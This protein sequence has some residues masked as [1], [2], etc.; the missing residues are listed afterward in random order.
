MSKRR[1]NIFSTPKLALENLL[2]TSSNEEDIQP[3]IVNS[4]VNPLVNMA[5]NPP[6]NP[7]LNPP[8]S[9]PINLPNVV[10]M[11]CNPK[12]VMLGMNDLSGFFFCLKLTECGRY[13]I[14][15]Q[16]GDE[17]QEDAD[18]ELEDA[19]E[20]I[21]DED[22]TQEDSDSKDSE[23]P[24]SDSESED[25]FIRPQSS[26]QYNTGVY[27]EFSNG[28]TEDYGEAVELTYCELPDYDDE[29]QMDIWNPTANQIRVGM[30]FNKKKD[31]VCAVHQWNVAFNKEIIVSES[32][33]NVWRAKCYTRSKKIQ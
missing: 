12:V 28:S 11:S 19:D 15:Q 14:F 17:E 21:Q 22:D 8:V 7:A 16:P 5:V 13:L 6:V 1:N 20:E 18:E 3:L 27:Q 25:V 24:P 31:V 26:E 29:D 10:G 23:V 30:F 2:E 9:P 32:R 33:P 4:A